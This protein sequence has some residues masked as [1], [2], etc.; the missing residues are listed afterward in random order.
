[1]YPECE[2]LL[3]KRCFH[4]PQSGSSR[5][6]ERLKVLRR[7][8]GRLASVW[9]MTGSEAP[10]PSST[11][12][13]SVPG[14]GLGRYL[15]WLVVLDL[16]KAAMVGE[17]GPTTAQA[18]ATISVSPGISTTERAPMQM[19]KLVEAGSRWSPKMARKSILR[20][21]A[22]PPTWSAASSAEAV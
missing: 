2:W 3:R 8:F 15:R 22:Y 18:T 4:S 16:E 6:K 12:L 1:M 19:R 20:T 9:L 21:S 7:P 11:T 17:A 10:G 13:P 5:C 14:L